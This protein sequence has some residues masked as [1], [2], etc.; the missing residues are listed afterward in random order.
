MKRNALLRYLRSQGCELLRE[1]GILGG[2]IHLKTNV[3]P[4]QGI[5][6]LKRYL[7]KKFVKI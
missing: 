4:Y 5:M 6:K 3:L 1:G 7:P 2:I